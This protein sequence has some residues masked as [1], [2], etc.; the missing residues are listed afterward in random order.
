[1][2]AQN[3]STFLLFKTRSVLICARE[4]PKSLRTWKM[5]GHYNV[6]APASSSHFASLDQFQKLLGH[7]RACFSDY[8]TYPLTFNCD[9]FA[10]LLIEV[11]RKKQIHRRTGSE[12]TVDLY[13][14]GPS[15]FH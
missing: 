4:L 15:L 14:K 11:K 9:L 5:I 8:K 6:I 7:S 3:V 13:Y 1:M 2:V 10:Y 12:N